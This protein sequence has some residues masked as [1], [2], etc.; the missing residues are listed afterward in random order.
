MDSADHSESRD[1][2]EMTS[3]KEP[4]EEPCSVSAAA[5]PSVPQA[6]ADLSNVADSELW[7]S[8][9]AGPSVPPA[10]VVPSAVAKSSVNT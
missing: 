5:A 8:L 7:A 10:R 4:Q 9:G 6:S 1:D 2:S 3:S